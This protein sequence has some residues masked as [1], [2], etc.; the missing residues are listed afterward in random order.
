MIYFVIFV[1]IAHRKA[2]RSQILLRFYADRP[3]L[4][5][6]HISHNTRSKVF[7]PFAWG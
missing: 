6:I 2:P 7:P 3:F 1:F 4:E 5:E